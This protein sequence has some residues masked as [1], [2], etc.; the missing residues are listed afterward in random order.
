MS[1]AIRGV[2]RSKLGV[3]L[4]K[5]T[6]LPIVHLAKLALSNMYGLKPLKIDG[7]ERS[8]KAIVDG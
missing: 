7:C 3:D 1:C 5:L 8:L 2:V 6:I 4:N